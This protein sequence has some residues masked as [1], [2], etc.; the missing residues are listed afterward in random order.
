MPIATPPVRA[1]GDVPWERLV[2]CTPRAEEVGA[3]VQVVVLSMTFSNN[4]RRRRAAAAAAAATLLLLRE[5]IITTIMVEAE[6]PR[7]GLLRPDPLGLRHR[8]DRPDLRRR[9]R[10]DRRRHHSP[11]QL[12]AAATAITTTTTITITT[13][14]PTWSTPS[15]ASP[16][17]PP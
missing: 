11:P 17:P 1:G 7:L 8:L 3:E 9:H 13:T 16:A 10:P 14:L 4:S 15:Q 12:Q 2:G 6:Y 5:I